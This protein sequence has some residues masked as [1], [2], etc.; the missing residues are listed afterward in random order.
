MTAAIVLEY[1]DI[2]QI[3]DGE[4][5]Y[6]LLIES[7]NDAAIILAGIIGEEA[8]VDLMNLEAKNLGLNNTYFA[9]PTGLDPDFIADPINYSTVRDLAKFARYLTTEKP[10]IWDIS[11]IPEF[12]NA[13]NTNE[14]LGKI[15]GII[16]GKTGE[17]P[18]AGECFLLVVG[19][20]KNKGYVINVILNSKNHFEEMEKLIGW[21]KYAYKW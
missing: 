12:G 5:L 13:T 4:L 14:L 15:S 1:Y 3:S 18:R 7:N 8:F 2:S 10:L 16:G 20:P 17:T 19:A 11:T 9:N 6:P 21:V